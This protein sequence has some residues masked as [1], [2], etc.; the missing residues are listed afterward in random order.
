M[1]NHQPSK[2]VGTAPWIVIPKSPDSDPLKPGA[3]YF[4]IQ[5]IGTQAVIDRRLFRRPEQLVVTSSVELSV[6]P[7]KGAPVTSIHRIRPIKAGLAEQLGLA[8]T[9]VD[10][11]PATMEHVSVAVD[12][13]L[14][15]KNQFEPLARL[16]NDG[17]FSVVVSLVPGV[18]AVAQALTGLSKSITEQFLSAEDRR[19]ILR[20]AS[21][22][23]IPALDLRDG[24]YVI[25][26]STS[27]QN[28]LP[29]PLP[30][31]TDL[32]VQGNDL[33]Y[34]GTAVTEWSYVILSI[35]TMDLRTRDLGRGEGW[36]EKLN[37]VDVTVEQIANDPF[38]TQRD[39][40]AA[41]ESCQ[42]T[43]SEVN[44][45]L[46]ESPHYLRSEAKDIVKKAYAEA[47]DRIF[48]GGGGALGAPP[49]LDASDRRLLEVESEAQ[50]RADVEA[51]TAAEANA[52]SRLSRLGF[53]V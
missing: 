52:R 1:A 23:S 47:R 7:F 13:M 45:L 42:Q 35:D 5:I 18:A 51:Y 25:L 32:H 28:A 9:L 44:L 33:L 27:E 20:F 30:Q 16:V 6:P 10:I 34:L 50:L 21:A 19:P 41:W 48:S 4:R 37:H 43:L 24:Y 22:L 46:L 53:L 14:D 31:A 12:F 8:G 11:V 17:A 3:G 26:G 29:R 2:S 15:S 49:S 38:A 39:R 36:Y 40:R